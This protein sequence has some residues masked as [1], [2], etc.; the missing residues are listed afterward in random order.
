MTGAESHSPLK[1]RPRHQALLPLLAGFILLAG[2]PAFSQKSNT[3]ANPQRTKAPLDP[4]KEKKYWAELHRKQAEQ[5]AAEIIWENKHRETVKATATEIIK[6]QEEVQNRIIIHEDG[7][8]RFQPER[9]SIIKR[10]PEYAGLTVVVALVGALFVQTLIRLRQEAELRKLCGGYLSDGTEVASYKLPEWFAPAPAPAAAPAEQFSVENKNESS[11]EV[12]TARPVTEFF[13][14]ASERLERLR[15]ALRELNSS[16]L[17]EDRQQSIIRAHTAICELRDNAGVWDLRP[18]WQMS[19]SLELLIKRVIDKPK[20]LTPSVIRTLAAAVDVLHEVCVPGVRPNLLN[21]PPLKL[22]AV[23]DDPLCRRALQFALEKASFTTDL[24]ECGEKA[25]ELAAAHTYDVVFMDIQM[26]GIDGLTAC[27][28]IHETRKNPTVPVI[29]VTVQS[30]FNTR[31]QLRLKGGADLMAKP[32]LV[33]ELAVRAMTFAMR[34]R[35]DAARINRREEVPAGAT[36][37]LQPPLPA[38]VNAARRPATITAATGEVPPGSAPSETAT[39]NSAEPA[40]DFMGESARLLAETRKIIDGLHKPG[41]EL[42]LEEHLGSL[43]LRVH[44][45]ASK[46][47]LA[48]LSIAA[49]VGSALEALVKRLYTNPKTVNASTLN[50]AANALRLL[51]NLCRPGTEQELANREPVRILVVDDEPLARRAIVGAL[52][53]AFKQPESAGDGTQAVALVAKTPYD[54]I[55]ADVQ[56]PGLDGFELCSAVRASASNPTTPVVFIT[57]HTDED[58]QTKAAVAGGND[59][60]SKPFLPIEITVKALT[61][62]WEGRLKN[63]GDPPAGAGGSKP[64]PKPAQALAA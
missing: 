27:G 32:F 64:A 19:S 21:D 26:P 57:T 62:A 28:Q 50:T 42:E 59:F 15:A 49:H 47:S 36:P 11:L 46:A 17:A 51:E 16:G 53:L 38:P 43:Y 22:L 3:T 37:I 55:F 14:K 9:P 61:F 41:S 45:L 29:F 54:V 33:F 63:L 12:T 56:M 31:A 13:E 52:Q 24:A 4:L 23:D 7:P 2:A 35:L 58:S 60:I 10:Y 25:V 6:A 34:G 30:D 40:G 44:T 8:D 18:A 5:R 20:D 1:Q 39:F 48:K